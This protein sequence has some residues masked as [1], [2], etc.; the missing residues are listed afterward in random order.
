MTDSENN[1]RTVLLV[2]DNKTILKLGEKVLQRAGFN[3][4]T[5]EDG[6]EGVDVYTENR[7]D[8]SVVVLD[9]TM[10]RMNGAEAFAAMREICSDVQVILSSGYDE[11]D[12]S[13]NFAGGRLAGFIQKPY[14]PMELIAKIEEVIRG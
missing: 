4:L 5:A 12:A 2:D 3:V 6:Q 9:L 13:G 10:P 7:D 1:N 11:S 8:I 14:R